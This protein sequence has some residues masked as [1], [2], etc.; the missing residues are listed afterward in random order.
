[1]TTAT[2]AKARRPIASR[3]QLLELVDRAMRVWVRRDREAPETVTRA[4]DACADAWNY[5]RFEVGDD[6]LGGGDITPAAPAAGRRPRDADHARTASARA[7]KSDDDQRRIQYIVKRY[8]KLIGR[9]KKPKDARELVAEE[10]RAG[11]HYGRFGFQGGADVDG[12]SLTYS[13][14]SVARVLKRF[15]RLGR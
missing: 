3:E 7:R 11:M 1:M 9:G 2:R 14:R 12:W 6:A 4:L 8:A 15:E 10:V 13:E 5:A